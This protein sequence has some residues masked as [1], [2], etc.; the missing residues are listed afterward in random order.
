[1]KQNS[2]A[3]FDY[4][5]AFIRNIGW[6]T[7]EEQESLRHKKIAIAGLGGVGGNHLLSLTR[8]GIGNFNI[9]DM[10]VFELVN[11]NRQVGATLDSIGKPKVDVMSQLALDINPTLNLTLFHDGLTKENF[12]RF[13]EG[14]D[15]C[16][17]ATDFYAIEMREIL[18]KKCVEHHVPCLVAAPLG[19]SCGYLIYIPGKMTLE[20]YFQFEK[21]NNA[22]DKTLNFII[23]LNPS[24]TCAKYLVVPS[25]VDVRQKVGPSL[26][27]ACT[28]CSGIVSAE[29]IKI[30][31]KRGPIY[32]LPYYHLF[33]PYLCQY[34]RGW[35]PFGNRNPLQRIK[36]FFLK[37]KLMQ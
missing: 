35:I 8:L 5:Q 19:M 27:T 24:L 23:G 30:L 6:F 2:K 25:S 22:F 4:H 32:S 11:F 29:A 17:D 36:R 18:Y 7:H 16:I 33:D 34:I 14:V 31:L 3:Q 12:D 28:L 1:M 37:R 26:S 10:D 21:E 20:T 9:A 13:L 15:V